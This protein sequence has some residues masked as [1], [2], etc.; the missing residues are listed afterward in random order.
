[1]WLGMKQTLLI[2]LIRF[3]ASTQAAGVVLLHGLW[4][5]FALH[6]WGQASGEWGGVS[7]VTRAL[8]DAYIWLGGADADG[9]GD[10]DNLL[11][12]W[13]RISVPIYLLDVLAR[14]LF[15]D[16]PPM[17]LWRMSAL[18]G[19]VAFLGYALAIWPIRA[20]EGGGVWVIFWIAALA[21]AAA[22]A[23]AWAVL[24]RR[25]AAWA[26][27]AFEKRDPAALMLG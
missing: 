23:A 8:W 22:L 16:R 27:A 1:M 12:V 3:A 21:V 7:T 15:G 19:G 24:A 4:M 25:A 11:A 13:A 14:K 5:L 10:L 17:S 20:I 2:Q 6:T 18:S 9:H 26:V